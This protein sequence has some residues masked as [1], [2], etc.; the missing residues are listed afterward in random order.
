MNYNTEVILNKIRQEV[1]KACTQIINADNHDSMLY[2]YWGVS[3]FLDAMRFE[4]FDEYNTDVEDFF[5]L[6]NDNVRT[7]YCIYYENAK[8]DFENAHKRLF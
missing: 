5:K 7:A 6:M 3:Y 4:F 8:K 1:E 2:N